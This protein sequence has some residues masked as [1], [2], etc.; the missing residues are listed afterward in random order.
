MEQGQDLMQVTIVNY[1]LLYE[2]ARRVRIF[3]VGLLI[4]LPN[5]ELVLQDLTGAGI[6]G[7]RR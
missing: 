4:N 2:G 6:T 7:N 1:G 5:A 3:L